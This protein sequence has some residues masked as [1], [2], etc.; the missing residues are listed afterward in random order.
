M[1]V[2]SERKKI[3]ICVFFSGGKININ[4]H[5]MFL[6]YLDMARGK[7]CVAEFSHGLQASVQSSNCK[8]SLSALLQFCVLV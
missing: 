3:K 1:L 8:R 5:N 7:H 6:T 2:K 4:G